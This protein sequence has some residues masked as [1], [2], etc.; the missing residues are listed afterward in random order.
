MTAHSSNR[1]LAIALVFSARWLPAQEA[2]A[3]ADRPTQAQ[4]KTWITELAN[5]DPQPF[6]EPYVLD[7]PKNIDRESL[8]IVKNAYDNLSAHAPDALPALIDSLED[9][10]YSYY[11]ESPSGA[12]ICHTVGQACYSIIVANIELYRPHATVL[13]QTDRPRTVHFISA[14]GGP[15]R[16]I[17]TRKTYS[18]FE[19]QRE[20]IEWALKQPKPDPQELVADEDWKKCTENL[21]QFHDSFIKA[22][23]PGTAENELWFEGK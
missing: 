8:K 11:Q 16:W 22:A 20:A 15:K 18:L 13:D 23:K 10:H 17:S 5:R 1:L 19:M 7:P 9:E 12:F 2:A 4:I 21:K 14:M 6:T 3:I